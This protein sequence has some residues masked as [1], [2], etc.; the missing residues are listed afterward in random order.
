MALQ[1]SSPEDLL[2][3]SGNEKKKEK[4]ESLIDPGSQIINCPNLGLCPGKNLK[5][6]F[7]PQEENQVEGGG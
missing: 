3:R 4:D 5:G 6:K 1:K 2:P 7:V